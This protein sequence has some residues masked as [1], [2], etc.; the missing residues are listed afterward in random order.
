M[1]AVLPKRLSVKQSLKLSAKPS[2]RQKSKLPREKPKEELL[3]R[4]KPRLQTRSAVHGSEKRLQRTM[5]NQDVSMPPRTM[6]FVL[7]WTKL[8]RLKP[9]SIESRK[10]SGSKMLAKQLTLNLA[11]CLTRLKHNDLCLTRNDDELSDLLLRGLL[12]KEPLLV[13]LKELL[14]FQRSEKL[15]RKLLKKQLV[16]WKSKKLH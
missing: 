5:I 6:Q 1:S 16:N 4:L 12:P 3:H 11:A 2:A 9:D 14:G 13:L 7:Q 10:L 8:R 15:L